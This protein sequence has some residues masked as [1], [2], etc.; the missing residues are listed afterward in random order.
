MKEEWAAIN[1]YEGYYEVSNLGRVKRLAN[2][3]K[4]GRLKQERMLTRSKNTSG[5]LSVQLCVNG[6]VKSKLV[7]RLVSEAFIPTVNGKNEVN[8]LDENKENNCVENLEWCNRKEN[9]N[10]GT[11]NARRR[12]KILSV[13]SNGKEVVFDS[14]SEAANVLKIKQPPISMVLHLKRRQYRGYRFYFCN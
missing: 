8:H 13:S 9:V 5:Y 11:A 3:L 1:G 6:S 12:K 7:H 4:N 14:V 2:L 10:Y